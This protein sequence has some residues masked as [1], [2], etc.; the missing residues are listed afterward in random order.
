MAIAS[1]GSSGHQSGPETAQR[2][3]GLLVDGLRF[4]APHKISGTD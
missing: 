3:V 1:L 2:M 4:G